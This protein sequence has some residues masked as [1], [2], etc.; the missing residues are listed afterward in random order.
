[1]GSNDPHPEPRQ[2]PGHA[3]GIAGEPKASLSSGF[4]EDQRCQ[5]KSRKIDSN[6]LPA[7]SPTPDEPPLHG[8]DDEQCGEAGV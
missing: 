8:A 7:F 5:N 4:H 1:M 6:T 3:R 2:G